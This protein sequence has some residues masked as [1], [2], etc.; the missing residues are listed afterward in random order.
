M[1]FR[2]DADTTP[3]TT[4]IDYPTPDPEPIVSESQRTNAYTSG[5][6]VE[7]QPRLI[8]F[9][10]Q[11]TFAV[12]GIFVLL[13]AV[14]ALIN[15][16]HFR[17]LPFA[18]S[19]K[20]DAAS[21]NLK[22]DG[23][24][25]AWISSFLLL[26]TSFFCFQVYQVRKFRADDYSGSYRVWVWLACGFILAS[27]DATAQISPVI[28]SLIATNW[29]EGF[30]SQG[31]NI[32]LLIVGIPA[33]S[34]CGRLIFELWRSRV[35]IGSIAIAAAAYAF[36]NILRLDLLPMNFA[37]EQ[38]V[39]ANSFAI[40]H[41]S[42]FFMVISYAR[43]VI[44]EAEGKIVAAIATDQI[45]EN[46]VEDNAYNQ[47]TNTQ[48]QSKSRPRIRVITDEESSLDSNDGHM[49]ST[50]NKQNVG[51][52]TA[53]SKPSSWITES[54]QEDG[55]SE[56]ELMGQQI[57]KLPTGKRNRK[58]AAKQQNANQRRAA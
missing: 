31:R 26:A 41:S 18:E 7:N 16:A 55:E 32:W 52:K 12:A 46:D 48:K 36:A 50:S 43:F 27:M 8:D 40:A 49:N 45:E 20:I 14:V 34:I 56:L 22:L 42:V 54:D 38:V 37:N 53:P 29:E 51:K 13:V 25:L 35:A 10:P 57:H 15:V 30:L 6:L 33:G 1:M 9:V 23:G 5:A 2:D 4:S 24:L 11:R 17:V 39:E 28:A 19:H 44:L 3:N 58:Q 21:L 47:K